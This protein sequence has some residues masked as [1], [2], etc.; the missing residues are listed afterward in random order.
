MFS[1]TLTVRSKLGQHCHISDLMW[2]CHHQYAYY[3]L[4]QQCKKHQRLQ[5]QY[6]SELI[7]LHCQASY[8]NVGYLYMGKALSQFLSSKQK[9]YINL[10]LEDFSIFYIFHDELVSRFG[11]WLG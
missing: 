4:E 11:D 9:E 6:A 10:L 8:K 1:N 5:I 3:M 7:R 2:N